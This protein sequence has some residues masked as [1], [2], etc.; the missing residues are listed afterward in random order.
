MQKESLWFGLGG[1][2]L[3]ALSGVGGVLT[4]LKIKQ[5]KEKTAENWETD[6]Y[7]L[8]ALQ[9]YYARTYDKKHSE[10]PEEASDLAEIGDEKV[11]TVEREALSPEKRKEIK[12]KLT[13]NYETKVNYAEM[14]MQE[15]L[16]EEGEEDELPPEDAE[17]L[18]LTELWNEDGEKPPELITNLEFNN[19]EDTLDREFLTYYTTNDALVSDEGEILEMQETFVG[20]C[21]YQ[22]GFSE[23]D[24]PLTTIYVLNHALRKAY[25]VTKVAGYY[26]GDI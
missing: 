21:L 19:L 2:V 26:D 7:D 17:M 6:D 5:K 20:D 9:S 13:R 24:N 18:R 1:F 4:Y 10:E 3:G 14:Y 22:N 16:E 11:V 8:G 12:E 23:E 25:A 15:A